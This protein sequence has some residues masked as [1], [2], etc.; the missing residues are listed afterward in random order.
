MKKFDNLNI[1]AKMVYLLLLT[2][3]VIDKTSQSEGY[4][5]ALESLNKAWDWIKYKNI[6]AY[7]LYLYLENMDEKDIM[8]YMELEEDPDLETAWICIGNALA[9]II[10]EAYLYEKEKYLPQTVSDIQ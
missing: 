8:T 2:E 1:D 3:L 6:D 10:R 7:S 4:E 5:I 9:Y